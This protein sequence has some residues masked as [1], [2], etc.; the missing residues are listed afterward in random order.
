VEDAACTPQWLRETV[1]PLLL[2][3]D[4]LGRMSAA[5]AGLGVRDA[6]ERLADM[7]LL[8]AGRPTTGAAA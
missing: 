2:D 6:D 4:R 3:P 8:A 1:L 7:V 5:A